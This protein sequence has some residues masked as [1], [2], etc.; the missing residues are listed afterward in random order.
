M[1]NRLQGLLRTI[2]GALTLAVLAS[3]GG[4]GGGGGGNNPPAALN[5]S[6]HG[7]RGR[8]RG[9]RLQPYHRRDRRHRRAQLHDQ[10]RRTAGRPRNQCDNRRRHRHAA[11][12]GGNGQLHDHRDGLAARRS[13]ATRRPSRST[14]STRSRSRPPRLPDTSVGVAY[15]QAITATGGTVP[16]HVHRQHRQPAGR[17]CPQCR[18][19]SSA[20]W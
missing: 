1:R 3:C 11:G 20:D 18:T 15:N 7:A 13:K 6:R 9:R 8:C 12:P 19:A 14:S 4:G 16:L 17:N 5:I 2:A 10:R